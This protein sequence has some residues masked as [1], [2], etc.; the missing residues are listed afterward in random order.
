MNSIESLID[1][2]DRLGK[3]RDDAWQVPRVEGELLHHIALASNAKLI[4]EVG[5]SYGFSALFW[6]RALAQTNG[7]LHTIDRDPKKFE[8]SKQTF[9]RAGVAHLITNHLGDGAQTLRKLDVHNIDIAFIDADKPAAAE[10]FSLLWPKIRPGGCVLIDNATTHKK[11]LGPFIE[12]LR[13][14]SDAR[15]TEVAIGNG[16]AWVIKI[17]G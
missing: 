6:A 16:L 4:V 9:A 8:S 5:T 17:A 15:T 1:E 3:T 14:R 7:H 13:S 2:L 11:E 10:H 12:N